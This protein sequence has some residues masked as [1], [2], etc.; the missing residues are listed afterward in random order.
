MDGLELI[1]L[2]YRPDQC[3]F[4]RKEQTNI[5]TM[6]GRY[7]NSAIEHLLARIQKAEP[8]EYC[9]VIGQPHSDAKNNLMKMCGCAWRYERLL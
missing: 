5:I 7:P 3:H 6:L 1:L 4:G 2:S 8:Q 9:V